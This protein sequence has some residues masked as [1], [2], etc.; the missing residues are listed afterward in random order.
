MNKQEFKKEYSMLRAVL[1][2]TFK[3]VAKDNSIVPTQLYGK[4]TS[5]FSGHAVDTMQMSYPDNQKFIP[6]KTGITLW[7]YR[8]RTLNNTTLSR[9]AVEARRLEVRENERRCR[10]AV[11]LSRAKNS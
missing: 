8:Y 2:G 5:V 7:D 6:L 9:N 3:Y 1:R 10:E 4:I 11:E